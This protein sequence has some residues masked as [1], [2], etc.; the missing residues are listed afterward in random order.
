MCI[1]VMDKYQP[2]MLIEEHFETLLCVWDVSRWAGNCVG[3]EGIC[4][5][6]LCWGFELNV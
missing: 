6:F 5:F 2:G 3:R 4:A 1:L